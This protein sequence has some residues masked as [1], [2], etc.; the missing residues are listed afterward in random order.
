MNFAL[1]VPKNI[2]ISDITEQATKRGSEKRA[3]TVRVVT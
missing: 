2:K 1:E 3:N